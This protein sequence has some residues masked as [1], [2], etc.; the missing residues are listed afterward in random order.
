ML[1]YYKHISILTTFNLKSFIL[2]ACIT[3]FYY[4]KRQKA[5]CNVCMMHV[6]LQFHLECDRGICFGNFQKNQ[7]F[8]KFTLSEP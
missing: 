8:V 5:N 7:H 4:G 1:K 2:L 6:M 3:G